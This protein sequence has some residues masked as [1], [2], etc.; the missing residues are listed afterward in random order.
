L[1]SNAFNAFKSAPSGIQAF[2]RKGPIFLTNR[3]IPA[4]N[5]R[6]VL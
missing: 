2:P 5:V 6:S 3:A 4:T 1:K